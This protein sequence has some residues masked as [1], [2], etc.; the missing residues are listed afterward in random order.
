MCLSV[1][2][3]M[4]LS[5]QPQQATAQPSS[6]RFEAGAHEVNEATDL[7]SARPILRLTMPPYAYELQAF[8]IA[9]VRRGFELAGYQLELVTLPNE[10]AHRSAAAGQQDGILLRESSITDK[11]NTLIMLGP[12]LRMNP[13]WVWVNPQSDCPNNLSELA[14]LRPV[15]ILGVPYFDQVIE[16]SKVGHIQ[17]H[18]P[19]AALKVIKSGRADYIT[20]TVVNLKHF[21][22]TPS[23]KLKRCFEQPLFSVNSHPF[24][25]VKHADK[26]NALEAGI[27]QALAEPNAPS[28]PSYNT[29]WSPKH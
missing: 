19:A 27:R 24:V 28:S 1:L 10:R 4:P 6:A 2:A 13:I 21:Q 12:A 5:A 22:L 8:E 7:A 15:S 16:L 29:S 18:S 25:H 11:Y 23:M 14:Q 26:V 17:T 20:G 3:S 9:I